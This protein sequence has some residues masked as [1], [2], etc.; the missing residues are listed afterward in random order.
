MRSRVDACR[1]FYTKE[2][3]RDDDL[4]AANP[5]PK[6][7]VE[8]VYSYIQ[9]CFRSQGFRIGRTGRCNLSIYFEHVYGLEY[10]LS[11]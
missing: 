6:S 1:D 11:V 2:M 5:G 7:A 8:K 9:L 10:W 4:S 3:H